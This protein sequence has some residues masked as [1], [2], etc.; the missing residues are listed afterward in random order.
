MYLI[1]PIQRQ[2]YQAYVDLA[3]TA[4]LGM[5]SLPKNPERLKENIAI[6]LKAFSENVNE[7]KGEFYLFVL[8]SIQTKQIGGVCGIYARIGVENPKYYYHLETE[9][10]KRVDSLPITTKIRLLRPIAISQGPSEICSLFLA[11]SFRKEGLGKLLS[12]SRFLFIAQF[13][14]RF[15]DEIIAEMRGFVN[16][17]N[18]NPFWEHVGRKFLN[19]SYPELIQREHQGLSFVPH[20]VPKHPL[21]LD[22]LPQEAQNAVG[23]I[24]ENTRPALKILQH[25]GFEPC[26][27]FDIFDAGPIVKAKKKQIRSI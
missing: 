11:P 8:E 4:K 20:V 23:K 27:L 13:P 5:L 6:S 1:R 16:Q 24:H 9:K 2:D 17:D 12:L 22:L 19:V 21:Y 10:V 26:G 15:A 25:Q 14:D 18:S 7:I 3:F